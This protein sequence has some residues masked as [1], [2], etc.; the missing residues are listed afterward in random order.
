VSSQILVSVRF[1][2]RYDTFN[3]H[4]GA[5]FWLQAQ[6]VPFEDKNNKISPAIIIAAMALGH[7]HCCYVC[8]KD[9]NA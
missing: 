4:F 3:V 7:Y 9:L 1:D 5:C 2:T 8:S 6:L